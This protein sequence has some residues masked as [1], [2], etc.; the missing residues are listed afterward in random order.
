MGF[1][2][3]NL[4]ADLLPQTLAHVLKHGIRGTPCRKDDE[5]PYYTPS[6]SISMRQSG[7]P[8][9]YESYI[10]A[11]GWCKRSLDVSELCLALELPES[12]NWDWSFG[13]DLIPLQLG[14]AVMEEV[15]VQIGVRMPESSKPMKRFR[16]AEQPDN[17]SVDHHWLPD[18]K[19]WMPSSW[20]DTGI[21]DRAV[22]ADGASIDF[23]PSWNQRITSVLPR[24]SPQLIILLENM[25]H[26]SW[27]LTLFRSFRA[28][29]RARHG[30]E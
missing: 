30:P 26:S 29:M 27:C 18:L 9:V 21:S 19:K 2:A 23:F 17:A 24:V 13:S 7:R 20:A 28:F 10:S 15:I 6:D 5:E 22:K 12:V 25:C 3:L 16:V 1:E 11:T 8:V 4:S 14:R